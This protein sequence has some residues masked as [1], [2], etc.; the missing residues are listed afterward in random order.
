M[1]TTVLWFLG[2][3]K[4]TTGKKNKRSLKVSKSSGSMSKL[5]SYFNK[6]STLLEDMVVGLADANSEND[7]VSQYLEPCHQE[8]VV[9]SHDLSLKMVGNGCSRLASS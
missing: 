6:H 3:I 8:T 5:A 7:D 9:F 1:F 2:F 4:I